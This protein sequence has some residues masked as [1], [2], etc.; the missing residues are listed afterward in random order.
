MRLLLAATMAAVAVSGVSPTA[1][2]SS[3]GTE[4]FRHAYALHQA[5]DYKAA[6]AKFEEV[7]AADSSLVYVYFFLAHSYD[8]Q[9]RSS[10]R[11]DAANDALLTKAIE[12][13]KKS[14]ES[15]QD[16]KIKRLALA[17]LVSVYGPEKLN[18]PGRAEP[19]LLT[20][21][22]MDPKETSDFFALANIYEQRGDFERAEKMLFDA[23]DASPTQPAVFMQ[24]AGFYRRQGDFAKTMAVLHSRANQEPGN[25]EVHYTIA[26]YYW[27]KAYR[28][29][30][31]PE[32][33]K[34][35][36]VQ[37][38]LQAVDKA[39]QLNPNYFEA[40]TYKSLLL[41]VQANLEKSPARQQALLKE[42]N[43]WLDKAKEVDTKAKA[44]GAAN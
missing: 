7:L 33:D 4:L 23:R 19:I 25:P 18:D 32:A 12:K 6:A 20:M 22:K 5:Q 43:Q 40:L 11:G 8:Q 35:K 2:N 26:T 41:R 34:V 14:A 15:E 44:A 24:L 3:R 30:T 36:F 29:F 1:Q 13:Y 37:Q 38:G 27:D 9:Y 16:P 28:D 42:A 17:F 39:I 10:L 21:I 31:A